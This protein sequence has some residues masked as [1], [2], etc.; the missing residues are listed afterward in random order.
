MVFRL[1]GMTPE[2]R[3]GLDVHASKLQDILVHRSQYRDD[4]FRSELAICCHQ[5][6]KIIQAR[7]GYSTE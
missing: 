4:A 1:E 6:V 7:L 2:L 3:A 5:M